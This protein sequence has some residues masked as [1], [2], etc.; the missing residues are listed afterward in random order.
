MNKSFSFPTEILHRAITNL[1]KA[2]ESYNMSGEGLKASLDG[3]TD[4][5][6]EPEDSGAQALE[7]V[8]LQDRR[9]RLNAVGGKLSNLKPLLEGTEVLPS[10]LKNSADKYDDLVQAHRDLLDIQEAVARGLVSDQEAAVDLKKLRNALGDAERKARGLAP[11]ARLEGVEEQGSLWH[12]EGGGAITGGVAS[13]ASSGLNALGG[14]LSGI[15]SGSIGLLAGLPIAGGIFG[16]LLYGFKEADRLKAQM[17]AMENIA[18]S[19]GA[20]G[21]EKGVQ[22]L[23]AFAERAQNFYGIS[24]TTVEGMLKQFVEAGISL[25][26]ILLQQSTSL[27]EAGHDAVTMSLALDRT[28]EVANGFTAKFA[29]QII[30]QYGGSLQSAISQVGKLEFAAQ[31]AGAGVSSFVNWTM[32][33]SAQVRELGIKTDEVAAGALEMLRVMRRNGISM[34][35]HLA[36]NS[37]SEAISGLANMSLG[38]EIWMAEGLGIGHGLAG[39][40]ALKSGMASGRTDMLVKA[41][42][43]WRKEALTATGGNEEAARFY[44]ERQGFGFQGS[45]AILHLGE[46]EAKGLKLDEMSASDKQAL[47]EAFVTEGKKVSSNQE[48]IREALNGMAKMGQGMALM[49]T[50]FLGWIIIGVKSMPTIMGF[51]SDTEKKAV[52][53]ALQV[54]AQGMQ[55]GWNELSIGG[56]MAYQGI[57][58]IIG[59]LLKPVTTAINYK[60]GSADLND[61]SVPTTAP[62]GMP[63]QT[64]TPQVTPPLQPISPKDASGADLV[65][66][67]V[68]SPLLPPEHADTTSYDSGGKKTAQID[69]RLVHT[70]WMPGAE[71]A[72]HLRIDVR[73]E[74]HA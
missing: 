6:R 60:W 67:Q 39:R 68:E 36:E 9:E 31:K 66:Q 59:P 64:P 19:A 72:E 27:G 46:M 7:L 10:V 50:N 65:P 71:E 21:K 44:L 13:L 45:K 17:G 73:V 74:F 52:Y 40:Q 15:T 57:A 26:E 61:P 23:G 16:L 69:P 3:L 14:Q 55:K 4:A 5:I 22:W 47:R 58:G 63:A 48:N 53:D 33:A 70:H 1:G 25:N 38:R 28:F 34:A 18:K 51:G 11:G 2:L 41:S 20:T 62:P 49:L 43:L 54:R 42:G 56:S 8:S 32:Q 30:A 29:T 37:M 24:R 12:R 35:S